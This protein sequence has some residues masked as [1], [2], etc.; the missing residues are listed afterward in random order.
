MTNSTLSYFESLS[1]DEI[2]QEVPGKW[3]DSDLLHALEMFSEMNDM[4]RETAVLEL[5][6]SSPDNNNDMVDYSELYFDLVQAHMQAENFAAA[7]HWVI[8]AMAYDFQHYPDET[9]IQSHQSNLA[10]IYLRQAELDA[11]LQ[12]ITRLIQS[13]PT[14]LWGYIPLAKMLSNTGLPDLALKIL[15]RA[16]ELAKESDLTELTSELQDFYDEL[17]TNAKTA[18]SPPS[19]IQ[20]TT[21][22][23]FHYALTLTVEDEDEPPFYLPP[24]ADLLALGETLDPNLQTAIEAQSKILIPELIQLA[25]DEDYWGTAVNRHTISLLRQIRKEEP[26]LNALDHWLEQAADENWP[27]L[28]CEHIG[29]IGGFT[30][31]ELKTIV[32]NTELD[33]FVRN[34]AAEALLEWLEKTPEQRADIIEYCRRLLTRKEAYEA[35][36]ELFIALLISAI[37]D[38]D[39]RELYPEIKQTFDEDRLDPTVTDLAFIHDKWDLPPLPATERREDGLYVQLECKK[40]QRTRQYFVQHVTIDMTTLNEQAEGQTVPYDPHIMDRP[41]ICPKCGAIDHYKTNPLTSMRLLLGGNIENILAKMQGEEPKKASPNQFVTQTRPQAFGQDMHPLVALNK[42]MQIALS[43]PK[44]AEPN[45]R[46]G[47]ILRTIWRDEEA[48]S[49]YRTALRLE[50]E[51]PW[52]NYATATT[53]HDL[54]NHAEAFSLYQK[55]IQ[56]ISPMAMLKDEELMGVSMSSAAGLQALKQGLPSPYAQDSRMPKE[57]K[58]LNRKERRAQE[59]KIK[60]LNKKKRR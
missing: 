43:N 33:T 18:V 46:M 50:P 57:E 38:Q 27:Q 35:D 55:A 20:P 31:P 54:G 41:I 9:D 56:L 32:S 28:L 59:R 26:A 22:A 17:T 8:A 11:G 12:L 13:D 6:L 2:L 4:E 58:K 7:T 23:Q 34:S 47:N 36:E 3:S 19:A 24:V 51:D 37:T 16:L 45:W 14:D 60:K 40:C 21:L 5:I 44:Q 25:F 42:Y 29:K 15:E 49:A 30:T 53:E 10:E 39:A 52:I 48:L 1:A